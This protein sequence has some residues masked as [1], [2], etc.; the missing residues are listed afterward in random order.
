VVSPAALLPQNLF[1]PLKKLAMFLMTTEEG[2]LE[3]AVMETTAVAMVVA[4]AD[5]EATPAVAAVRVV[6][7]MR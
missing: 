5:V 2:V 7:P 3:M 4:M 6:V 1:P